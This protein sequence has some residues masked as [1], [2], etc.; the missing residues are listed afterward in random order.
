MEYKIGVITLPKR[1]VKLT[2]DTRGTPALVNLQGVAQMIRVPALEAGGRRFK[3][4]LP[5]HLI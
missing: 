2:S 5:D 4:Y 1:R 3:S